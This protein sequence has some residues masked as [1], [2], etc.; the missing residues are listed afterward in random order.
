MSDIKEAAGESAKEAMERLTREFNSMSILERGVWL[1]Q[2]KRDAMPVTAP[3][4]SAKV[5][6][7]GEPVWQV[8][9]GDTCSWHDVTPEYYAERLP[10]NRR[11]LYTAPTT[12][13]VPVAT[14]HDDGYWTW[15][16]TPPHESNYAGW[17]MDVYATPASPAESVP[18]LSELDMA[19]LFVFHS[20]VNDHE[21]DGYTA[22]KETMKRLA[23]LGV[24]NSLGFGRYE[25]TA[26]GAWLVETDFEQ[27]PTLPLRTIAEHNAR[28]ALLAASMGGDKHD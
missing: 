3:I 27:N 19:A 23:E 22:R 26:F 18:F 16:G 11:I 1:D 5:E 21:A 9:D 14:L 17:R 28:S 8:W 25:T 20:Q 24:V 13:S 6:D 12:G 10:S 2:I 4:D 15:K 7:T